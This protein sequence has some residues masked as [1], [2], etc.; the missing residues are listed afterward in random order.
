MRNRLKIVCVLVC[1]FFCGGA[2]WLQF[3][4]AASNSVAQGESLPENLDG[5]SAIAWRADLPGRG[6]SSPIVIGDRVVLTASS[7]FDQDRLHVLCFE[8]ASGR[9]LWERQFWATGRTITHPTSSTAAPTPASD[10]KLVFAFY[11]S[12][13][14]I[15]L[16]LDGNLQWLR[17]LAYD[18]PAAG[19]DVGMAS[20]PAVVGNTV[21]VQ[22]E[23]QGDSFAAG[24][25]RTTG[26]TLWRIPRPP[27][28]SWTSPIVMRGPAA[29]P[30]VL[31]QSTTELTAH[32]PATGAL[33][34]KFEESC[35]GIPSAVTS[36]GLVFVP[37]K[38]VTALRPTPGRAEPDVL[39]H[40]NSLKPGAASLVA[41]NNR[42]YAVNRAG[43]LN[44]A[45]MQSGR[46]LGKVRLEGSFWSTPA[47]VGD[48]LLCAS[49]EGVLEVVR[50]SDEMN[51]TKIIG[52]VPLNET[53]QSSPAVAGGAV[54]LRSDKHLW[55]IEGGGEGRR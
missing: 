42:L 14:L 48:R 15:C 37:S 9:Q 40:E 51:Q 19:N 39:W 36:G 46:S 50:L 10:G 30:V 33:L 16:D 31:L 26:R 49:H 8:A 38:G 45:D 47:L 3:R 41:G 53:I 2:D 12:N 44:V 11:S 21:I 27:V 23:N 5:P 25:D 22:I 28:A 7:G 20:S 55:K 24:L 54:Y 29:E 32:D 13:D 43:V 4:T 35:E 1:V 18:Y 52:R 6:A 34:W 17:G